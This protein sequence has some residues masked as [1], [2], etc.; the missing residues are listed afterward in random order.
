[1]LNPVA[2]Q[3]M[4]LARTVLGDNGADQFDDGQSGERRTAAEDCGARRRGAARGVAA[5][6]GD[7]AGGVSSLPVHTTCLL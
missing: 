7:E 4:A 1:M 2:K 6:D 3:R 5:G